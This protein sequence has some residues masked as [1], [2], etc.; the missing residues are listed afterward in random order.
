MKP[1]MDLMM[2]RVG[3]NTPTTRN[4]METRGRSRKKRKKREE[5][6]EGGRRPQPTV[7]T[8]VSECIG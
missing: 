5:K 6:E 4:S 2:G 1:G 8:P 7:S 3:L